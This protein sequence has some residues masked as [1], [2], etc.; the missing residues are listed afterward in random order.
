MSFRSRVAIGGALLAVAAVPATAEGATKRP[1][2]R[3]TG[4]VTATNS[5]EAGPAGHGLRARGQ[6]QGAP[7]GRRPPDV[8]AAHEPHRA[9][10]PRARRAHDQAHQGR[11]RPPLQGQPA[12]SRSQAAGSLLPVRVRSAQGQEAGE[13]RASRDDGDPS[14]QPAPPAA[15]GTGPAGPAG[16]GQPDVRP[17]M[18]DAVTA[19][20]MQRHLEAFQRIADA[21][22]GNR[23]SGFPGY[24]ASAD[25]VMEQLRDAG[26]SP[27]TQVFDFV[28]FDEVTPPVFQQTAPTARTFDPQ[29]DPE[30]EDFEFLSMNYSDSGD[31]T[32]DLVPIDVNLAAVP[33][34]RTSTSGCEDADFTAAS[35][36]AGDIALIQRGTCSFYDKVRKAQEHDA[37][38]VVIFNQGNDAGRMDVVAGTLGETAQDGDST[39]RQTSSLASPDIRSTAHPCSSRSRR[40]GCCGRGT[41]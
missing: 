7:G 11:S 6:S 37:A 33:A 9:P 13:V 31:A 3:A 34:N 39:L 17:K 30:D 27:T 36:E 15:P 19:Q 29:E 5:V 28:V 4:L 18:R 32:G 38:G 8:H 22:D 16:A 20:G 41:G 1:D 12:H 25:Y 24:D 35:F 21:N 23:A 2:L 14:R 26:Y 10:R 40:P